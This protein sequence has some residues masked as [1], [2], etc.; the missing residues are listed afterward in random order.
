MIDLHIH[1]N[2]SDGN[3]TIKEILKEAQNLGL[4]YISITD[5]ETCDAYNELENMN[6]KDYFSGNIITGIELKSKYNDVVMDVL[7]YGIDYKIMN[8]YLA[9]CYKEITWEKTQESQL[10]DF[11]KVGLKNNLILRPI[12][13]LKWNKTKDW[14]SLVFYNEIKSHTENQTKVPNDLWES[15]TNFKTNHY[16]IKGDPFYVN[17]AKN[18]PDIQK[19]IDIIHK[20][21]GKAFIAHIYRYKEINNKIIELEN[22]IK[23]YCIDGIECY[24]STFLNDET[25]KLLHIAKQHNLLISGGSD[26][27]GNKKTDILLGRG[28]GKLNVPED[29]LKNWKI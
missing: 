8:H 23:K 5:H 10:A 12:N 2:Y 16:H 29:I 17:M 3:D 25:E 6:V 18:Y 4:S 20:S 7:G 1:S 14:A 26:Y 28:K 15:F 13:E 21:G 19:V 9:E 22:I 11:Y 24:Y 27:H